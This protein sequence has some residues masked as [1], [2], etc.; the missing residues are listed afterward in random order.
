MSLVFYSV[1]L[2]SLFFLWLGNKEKK[3]LCI[4]GVLAGIALGIKYTSAMVIAPIYFLILI[5]VFLDK[6]KNFKPVVISILLAI[7]FFSPWA[8]KNQYYFN[9]IFFPYELVSANTKSF[10]LLP[11]DP[12]YDEARKNEINQLRHGLISSD[13]FSFKTFFVAIWKQSLGKDLD[14]GHWI[15]FGFL[16]LLITPFYLFFKKEKKLSIYLFISM[17][18]FLLWYALEGARTWYAIFGIMLLYA[19]APFLLL[20]N[21]FLS[22]FA[23]F[24]SLVISIFT[25]FV[26]QTNIDYLIG[27]ENVGSYA[28][29]SISYYKTAEFINDNLK[30]ENGEKILIA[31]D[32]RTAFIN[33]NDKITYCDS[34]LKKISYS[35]NQGDDIFYDSLKNS[36]FAYVVYSKIML[37]NFYQAWPN[38]H[39]ITTENYLLNYKGKHPSIYQNI[40]QLNSFL[41]KNAVIIY[42]DDY[43]KLYKLK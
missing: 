35:I 18:Y 14:K 26:L 6:Q 13:K 23:V 28:Q 8:L 33:N 10:D 12:S 42:E 7:L 16:P 29:K 41:N 4:L 38:N 21:K 24:F 40:R 3:I 20:K 34:Y 37:D 43:N 22:L 25:L 17:I 27:A 1:L 15:N 36:S 39:N 19:S 9:N 32:F 2:L 11:A 5:S 30:L 31:G